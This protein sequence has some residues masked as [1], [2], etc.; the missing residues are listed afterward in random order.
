MTPDPHFYDP[1]LQ[2]PT[3]PLDGLTL[4]LGGLGLALICSALLLDRDR[5]PQPVNL[6]GRLMLQGEPLADATVW[7]DGQQPRALSD[8]LG[9]FRLLGV[10]SG[11]ATLMV[12][13]SGVRM[14]LPMK[15]PAAA[16]WNAG[17][18]PC[19]IWRPLSGDPDQPLPRDGKVMV[20]K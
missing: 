1:P 3:R 12:R 8:S 6:T 17:D 19:F 4:I 20:V 10:S 9:E 18:L 2:R 13:R 11:N 14:G 5:G 15:I 16:S 7:L